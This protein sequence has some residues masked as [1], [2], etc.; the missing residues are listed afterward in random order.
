[1]NKNSTTRAYEGIDPIRHQRT[2]VVV[3][4]DGHS[5]ARKDERINP[6][7][8]PYSGNPQSLINSRFW[9]PLQRSPL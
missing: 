4:N 9:D 8:D 5:E 6:P 7:Y 3:F 1:M 2:G